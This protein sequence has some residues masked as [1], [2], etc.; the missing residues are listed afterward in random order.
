MPSWFDDARFGMFIHWGHISQRGW[1]LSWP[2]VGGSA[3]LPL[4]QDVPAETYHESARS[5]SPRPQ[6][7]RTWLERARRAGMRY[8]VLTAKHHDGFALW[9]TRESDF[10][11]EHSAYRGDIVREFVEAAR[12]LD[13]KLGLSFS[14]S[15][16]HHADYPAFV[17]EHRPY[18]SG[19]KQRPSQA[20]WNR[21]LE[22]MFAQ[23]RELLTLY[24]QLDLLWFDGQWERSSE[25][26]EA[27]ELHDLIRS[28]QPGVLINERLPG[29]GDF[30]S[31]EPFSPREAPEG[32]WETRLP[33]NES[34][35]YNRSDTHYKSS[36][37]L[38]HALCETVSRGGNLLLNVSPMGSGELPEEQIERIDEIIPWMD[39]YADAIYGSE[40]GLEAWQ[41]YGPTTRRGKIVYLHLLSRPYESVCVRGIHVNRVLRVRELRSGW[42]LKHFSR[43]STRDRLSN[44]DPVGDLVIE[45]PER[46]LDPLATIIAVEFE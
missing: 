5:F 33:M 42:Q 36:R 30:S 44:D 34:W 15:D 6:S 4:C 12:E 31:V 10:S 38:V 17:D 16:W 13:I 37:T 32:R 14:L 26:W 3:A 23:V 27:R 43:T 25:E 45:V 24:G 21:Y 20:Q 28:F 8:A 9:H 46:V 29:Y 11:V 2:L 39:A 40:P 18:S 1:E 35:G 41:F 22:F 19:Q 7:P